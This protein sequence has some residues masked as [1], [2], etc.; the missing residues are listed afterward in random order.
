MAGIFGL[1]GS[2]VSTGVT[3][4]ATPFTSLISTG[5]STDGKARSTTFAVASALTLAAVA[6]GCGSTPQQ[7]AG[8]QHD[9]AC[10][11]A[12]AASEHRAHQ[13]EF[14]E[15]LLIPVALVCGLILGFLGGTSFGLFLRSQASNLMT[16]IE[17]WRANRSKS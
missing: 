2:G 16:R 1:S 4:T 5:L 12:L 10:V 14:M 13:T 17:T 8:D 11:Q 9:Q 6:S 7:V 3:S 15:L